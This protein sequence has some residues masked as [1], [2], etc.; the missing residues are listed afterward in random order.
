MSTHH[1]LWDA[2]TM[3]HNRKMT[4]FT[5]H[6]LHSLKVYTTNIDIA[7]LPTLDWFEWEWFELGSEHLYGFNGI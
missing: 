4:L 5:R 2:H 7:V 6:L 3:V 1:A